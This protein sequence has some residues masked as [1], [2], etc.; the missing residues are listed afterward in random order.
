[1]EIQSLKKKDLFITNS[2][3]EPLD[4]FVVN[5]IEIYNWDDSEANEIKELIE[6]LNKID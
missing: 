1:M 3:L 6:R 2:L 4:D 5:K